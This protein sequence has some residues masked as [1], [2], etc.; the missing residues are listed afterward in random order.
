MLSVCLKFLS[1]SWV[2]LTTTTHTNYQN[3]FYWYSL[4]VPS[5][6]VC[7]NWFQLV[8]AGFNSFLVLVYTGAA[9][10]AIYTEKL[11]I[12]GTICNKQ[13]TT[14]NYLQRAKYTGNDLQR[15]HFEITLQ[16]RAILSLLL[17]V[18]HWTFDCIHSSI[19]SC[20]HV[21]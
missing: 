15:G 6:L 3:S 12:T 11:E 4:L 10:L 9:T 19:T 17:N 21:Y 20:Y 8:P 16:H 1:D 18:F 7:S 2:Q 14:W 5:F 13:E